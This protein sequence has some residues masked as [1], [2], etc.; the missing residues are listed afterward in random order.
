MVRQPL[1]TNTILG[2]R[3]D[4]YRIDTVIGPGGFGVTYLARDV[5]FDRDVAIKEY[6]PA[7]FAFRDGATTIRSTTRG[8]QTDFFEQG[9]RSFLE[10]AR[11]L[12][13]FRHDNIVR[14]LNLFEQFNTAY[15]VL[16]FEEGQS[17]KQWLRDLGRR[18]NQA[19]VDQILDPMLAALETVHAKGL[20]HR[21]IAPDNII[22]RPNGRPV[23]IDFGAARTFVREN[24]FTVGAIVKHGYSPPEQYTLDTKLQ[25]AWS[26]IYALCATIYFA[27]VGE[28]PQEASSR[29][30][31]DGVL[32]IE[33]HLD[34]YHRG[35][36]RPELIA[37]LNAGLVLKPADRPPTVGDLRAIL[38]APPATP[39]RQAYGVSPSSAPS[40]QREL[41]KGADA[42]LRSPRPTV[43]AS[44]GA[45]QS[46]T[47][48]R[49]AAEPVRVATGS[50]PSHHQPDAASGQTGYPEP[51]AR[52]AGVVA[53][54]VAAIAAATFLVI[55]GISHPGGFATALFVCAGLVVACLERAFA[56]SW[57]APDLGPRVAAAA[58]VMLALVM[59]VYWVPLFLWPI[60]VVLALA[61]ALFAW[62]RFGRWVPI[63]LAAM[64][65]VHLGLAGLML[66]LATR[67]VQKDPLFL[68]MMASSLAVIAGLVLT[69]AFQIR[70]RWEH[71]IA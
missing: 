30:L 38:A 39:Q 55:G 44:P 5:R 6:F 10:E 56:V 52:I 29:Q 53:L 64:A 2:T 37:A 61:A 33:Q 51:A 42:W 31:K 26:D 50:P 12:G 58:A 36:Y 48:F 23:L 59:A 25:G 19:E 32:P 20:F 70:R 9:K 67:S 71:Q 40:T 27:I 7:D 68:P 62:G 1:P 45:G 11:I 65:L 46:G 34:G 47:I 15:M 24:S 16:E 63:S 60:S 35:L 3:S 69:S 43:A 28:A 18:P 22:I 21:D 66:V 17:L 14:V 13:K 4:Q 57:S 54:A 8:G 41:I 49:S